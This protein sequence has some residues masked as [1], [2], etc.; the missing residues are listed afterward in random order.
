MI[1][2]M[3]TDYFPHYY[4][5][6]TYSAAFLAECRGVAVIANSSSMPLGCLMLQICHRPIHL[7]GISLA[8]KV[9]SSSHQSLRALAFSQWTRRWVRRCWMFM[10]SILTFLVCCQ[11]PV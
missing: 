3:N 7:I 6:T 2:D 11:Y 1:V 10:E 4:L 8:S 5:L 9:C